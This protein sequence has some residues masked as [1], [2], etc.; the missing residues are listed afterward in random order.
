MNQALRKIISTFA[1]AAILLLNGCSNPLIN[2]PGLTSTKVPAAQPGSTP[3]PLPAAPVTFNVTLP[4]PLLAGETLTLSIVDEVTGLGLNPV[5][6]AMQSMDATHFSLTLPFPVGSIITYRYVRQAVLPILEDNAFEKPVRYRIYHANTPGMVQDVV[7]SWVDTPFNAP[8]GWIS[9][10]IVNA[11]DGKPLT[12]ILV[13]AGGQQRLTD[14]N[15]AYSIDG[16]PAGTHNLVAYALDGSHLTFQQGATVA[17]GKNTPANISM[18]PA[19]LVTVSFTVSVPGDT[20]ANAPIRLA[21]NLYTLGNTFGDLNA[22][23]STVAT[24]M[25]VLSAVG[26]GRY[27]IALMLPAGADI[28]Y[29]YTLGDGFWNAEHTHWRQLPAAPVDRSIRTGCRPGAGHGLH[30]EGW[31]LRAHLLRSQ[32]PA[33]DACRGQRIHPIQSLWL[34]G[35]HPDV[36]AGKQP[37]GIQALQ[38]AEHPHQLRIPV[39]PQRCLRRGG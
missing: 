16:L 39:L 13:A 7:S 31:I 4:A 25:P 23:L 12:N 17:E 1:L 30:L 28:R 10:R 15:G 8:V 22:G 19:P 2:I 37:L 21:G 32:C 6:H 9:G 29:K 24:R 27:T 38:S 18:I 33:R 11:L 5:N 3:A 35:T 20:A 34:D 26:D 14:S 36:A